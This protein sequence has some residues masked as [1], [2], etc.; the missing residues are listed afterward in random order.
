M[1]TLEKVNPSG[2]RMGTVQNVSHDE[3][4]FGEQQYLE[5]LVNQSHYPELTQFLLYKNGKVVACKST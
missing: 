3:I 5:Q 2:Y 1:Y 4:S